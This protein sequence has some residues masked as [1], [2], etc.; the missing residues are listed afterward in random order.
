M[1][2]FFD[3]AD[4]GK[5]GTV[6]CEEFVEIMKDE[7]VNTWL[8]AMD[9]RIRDVGAERVFAYLA[10]PDMS[11]TRDELCF[12]MSRLR[13][14]AQGL[15][16]LTLLELSS[17]EINM[18]PSKDLLRLTGKDTAARLAKAGPSASE[19]MR[20]AAAELTATMADLQ[21]AVYGRVTPAHGS[22]SS[23]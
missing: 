7:R 15:D 12:G 23:L 1:L 16:V 8:E 22:E 10:G 18:P 5:D 14:A 2:T 11:L 3:D 9:L 6:S 19:E 20:Q 4:V 13:G 17:P 21:S